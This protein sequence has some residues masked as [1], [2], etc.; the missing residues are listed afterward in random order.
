M[1]G[2]VVLRKQ[3]Y[4]LEYSAKFAWILRIKGYG[5]DRSGFDDWFR[6]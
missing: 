2:N 3:Q 1:G 4:V 5:S 6:L